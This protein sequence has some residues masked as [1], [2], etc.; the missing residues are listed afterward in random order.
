VRLKRIVLYIS[1]NLKLNFFMSPQER[2]TRRD[3]MQ[4]RR[5]GAAIDGWRGQVR[6]FVDVEVVDALFQ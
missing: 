4:L 6:E 1:Y 2:R 3:I 5:W